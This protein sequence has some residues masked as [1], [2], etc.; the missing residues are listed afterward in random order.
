MRSIYIFFLGH[1]GSGSLLDA[2]YNLKDA[3]A[4]EQSDDGSTVL[5]IQCSTE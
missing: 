2:K 1:E 4:A 3:G 5:G